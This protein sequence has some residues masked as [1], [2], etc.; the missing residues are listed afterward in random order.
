VICLWR[1]IYTKSS[2]F[3]LYRKSQ[4]NCDILHCKNAIPDITDDIF[5]WAR[6]QMKK[7]QYLFRSWFRVNRGTILLCYST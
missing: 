7:H 4:F 3:C 5:L 1:F 6:L 2:N